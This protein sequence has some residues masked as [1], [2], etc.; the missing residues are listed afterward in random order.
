MITLDKL[1]LPDIFEELTY[2]HQ[3]I[4]LVAGPTGSG[5]S[6]T[7]TAM[8]DN[9]NSKMA[10]HI[11]TIEDPVEYV[12]HHK[13]SIV[14]AREVHTDT[15]S[16]AA[17]MKSALRQN[18]DVVLLGEMR[19]LESIASAITIAET[20]HLVFSTIH[21]NSSAQCVNKI[22]DSF[23]ADQQN[24]IRLQLS[25]AL[26]AIISQRLVPGKDG[27]SMVAATEVMINNGAI[28]NLIRESQ[29]HQ[30]E[31]VIQMSRKEGMYLLDDDLERLVLEDKITPEVALS[32]CNNYKKMCSKLKINPEGDASAL[33]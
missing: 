11:I 17:A 20:G 12:H 30:I 16:F 24:Q 1:N 19:D 10:K 32:K 18:P 6:T 15:A 8:V 26:C 25:E 31:S 29:T 33:E 9:V 23:G 27:K 22:I 5:K 28:G 4:I 14:E 13:K 21:A 3:G 2:K 7:L